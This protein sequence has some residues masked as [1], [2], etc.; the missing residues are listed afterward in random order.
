MNAEAE[1][2][3]QVIT[4]VLVFGPPLFMGLYIWGR[5]RK[6]IKGLGYGIIAILFHAFLLGAVIGAL[7]YIYNYP[8]WA[9]AGSLAFLGLVYLSQWE[10]SKDVSSSLGYTF[11]CAMDLSFTVV[12]SLQDKALRYL[13]EA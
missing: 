4:Y 9:A 8:I 7:P 13:L 10:Y 11:I 1:P 3:L 2:L 5:D 6:F 12:V